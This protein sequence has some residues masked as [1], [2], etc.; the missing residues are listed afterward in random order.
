MKKFVVCNA[1]KRVRQATTSGEDH[2]IIYCKD[3]KTVFEAWSQLGP[4]VSKVTINIFT[5]DPKFTI[6]PFYMNLQVNT[7]IKE[8]FF[9]CYTHEF[10]LKF[11]LD[12][13]PNLESLNFY[14]LTKEK[15]K[16]AAENL[17]QLTS[18]YCE[19]I[20]EDVLDFYKTMKK[21]EKDINTRIKIN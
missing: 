16:Y 6:D 19:Y 20:E 15:I 12:T 14:K 7:N 5:E 13:C 1:N 9:N 2:T 18:I 11:I 4:N 10:W 8:I 3:L 17:E 21:T